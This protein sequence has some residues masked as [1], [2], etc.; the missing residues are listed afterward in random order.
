MSFLTLKVLRFL[1]KTLRCFVA[2]SRLQDNSA[3]KSCS[4]RWCKKR[5][6]AIFSRYRPLPQIRLRPSYFCLAEG[7]SNGDSYANITQKVNSRCF[8]LY[9]AYSNSSNVGEFFWSW[10]LKDYIEVEGKKESRCLVIM[11]S[12]KLEIRNFHVV[13][14]ERRQRNVQKCVMHVQNCCFV[15]I[16]L[17][18]FWRCRCRRLCLRRSSL[19]KLAAH[20]VLFSRRPYRCCH[21]MLLLS[22]LYELSSFL[23]NSP[24]WH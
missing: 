21:Q 7:L 20:S 2:C 6:G 24:K 11:S 23:K 1:V 13:V 10:S 17:L 19:L 3:V 5:T 12:T 16:N 8:K 4:K 9:R 14:G 15:D 18:L 22:F